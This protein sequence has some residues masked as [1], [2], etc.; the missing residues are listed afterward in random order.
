MRAASAAICAYV[1]AMSR[2][3]RM[4]AQRKL[5]IGTVVSSTCPLLTEAISLSD[6]DFIFIDTEH[7]PIEPRLALAMAQSVRGRCLS[8]IRTADASTTIIEQALDVGCDAIVVP[9][10]NSA[11]IARAV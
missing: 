9:Q 3:A 4:V 7:A 1:A 6:L 5:V 8:L 11:E 2:L 10:V